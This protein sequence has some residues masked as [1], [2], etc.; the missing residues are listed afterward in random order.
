M[1][2]IA[3]VVAVLMLTACDAAKNAGDASIAFSP[4]PVTAV[5]FS[6][7]FLPFAPVTSSCAVGSV[8][9]TG[10]NLVIV[11][12]R[13][14]F[15]DQV[16]LHLLDGSNVGGP[17]VTFPNAQL[18]NMFGSTLV[19]SSRVFPFRPEFACGLR[20]PQSMVANIVLIDGHGSS[21][22]VSVSAAFQ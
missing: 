7:Q 18:T 1:K 17:T 2:I 14:S 6:P 22:N 16:T 13:P 19:V 15:L 3:V 11:G 8:F 21:R 20:R 4:T 5:Q 10:F 12:D 9:S